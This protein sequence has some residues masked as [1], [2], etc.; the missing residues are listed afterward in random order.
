MRATSALMEGEAETATNVMITQLDVLSNEQDTSK[1]EEEK[2]KDK[3]KG[4]AI[5]I[6]QSLKERKEK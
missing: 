6:H 3:D 4:E 1:F 2:E 5:V